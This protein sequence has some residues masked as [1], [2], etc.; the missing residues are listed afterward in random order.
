M[1]RKLWMNPQEEAV[2]LGIS[3][4]TLR[5]WDK[6]GKL[7]VARTAVNH[8]HIGMPEIQR[9]QRQGEQAV[10]CALSARVSTFKQAQEGNLA[11]QLERLR[12]AA[13]ECEYQLV[14][15]IA[16]YASSLK[17]KRRGM[18]KLLSLVEQQEVDVVLIEYPDRLVRFGFF[19]LQET[20]RWQQVRLEVLDPPGQVDPTTDLLADMLPIVTVFSGNLYAYR[21]HA[22]PSRKKALP[23]LV[24]KSEQE[25]RAA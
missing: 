15:T 24:S 23:M 6:A 1:N 13:A 20:F 9:L 2:S 14:Q 10:R 12:V 22:N 4:K 8:R 17:E 19:S 18:K 21:A 5:R 7:H 3:V 25:E 16:K 11:R